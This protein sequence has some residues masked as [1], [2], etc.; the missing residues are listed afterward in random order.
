MRSLLESLQRGDKDEAV[1]TTKIVVIS[2]QCSG[3]GVF[4]MYGLAQNVLFFTL[5]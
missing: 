1:I 2:S 4:V 3:S 5:I